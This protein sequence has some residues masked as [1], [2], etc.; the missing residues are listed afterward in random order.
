[1]TNSGSD[2]YDA[3]IEI[4]YSS[5]ITIRNNNVSSNNFNGIYLYYSS[6]NNI[7]GNIASNNKNDGIEVWGSSNNIITSNN[8]SSNG[9]CGFDIYPGSDNNTISDNVLYSNNNRGIHV[10]WADE[11]TVMNN[12]VLNNGFVGIYIFYSYSNLVYHNNLI[13]NKY[14]AYDTH[15]TDNDW[16]HQF[17]LEG[18]YWSEYTGVDDG[19]GTGKHAIAGDCIGDTLIPHP[20]IDYDFYPFVKPWTPSIVP[21]IDID[22][23]TLNLKSKGKWITCYIMPNE[24]Y[25]PSDIDISTI[26]L[27]DTIPAEW[28]DIQGD[29]LM[30]KFDR[31]EVEDMLPVG[32]YNLK[33]TGELADGTSFEGYSDEIRVIDPG[34]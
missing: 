2:I 26:L 11:N 15:P 29:T 30:V 7:I 4:Y 34:K 24:P 3:G 33:V 9:Q 1:M 31:S 22:P 8:A 28:G 21:S 25:G 16:Y 12:N 5:N 17:L 14:Q 32:T 13:G 18:N 19:S 23:N 10:L 20:G 27:E 6:T